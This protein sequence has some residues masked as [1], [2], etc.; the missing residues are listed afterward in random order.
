[1]MKPEYRSSL[2]RG[3]GEWLL[4]RLSSLYIGGFALFVG[5]KLYLQPMQ[6]YEAWT[7]W[8]TSTGMGI[9]FAIFWFSIIIHAWIGLRS[10]IMDYIKPFGLR[11]IIL[12]VLVLMFSALTLW[13]MDIFLLRG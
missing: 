9:A 4:Q 11:F 10:V 2:R 5:V 6:S 13:T 12:S 8:A 3:L 1:M 7:G